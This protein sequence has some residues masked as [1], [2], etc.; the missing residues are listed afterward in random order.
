MRFK[1]SS[2]KLVEG[3]RSAVEVATKNVNTEF[4][5]SFHITLD[6]RKSEIIALA[7]GGTACISSAISGDNID[8]LNYSCEEE[9]EVTINASDFFASLSSFPPSQKVSIVKNNGE[10]VIS[11]ENEKDIFQTLPVL[12]NR[13]N[14]S[15]LPTSFE[16]EMKINREVFIEGLDKVHFAIGFAET[17]P[18]YLCI[19]FET[20]KDKAR[21]AAGT[22][23]RFAIS[24]TEGKNII[25]TSKKQSVLFPKNNISTIINVL[26]VDSSTDISIKEAKQTKNSPEQIVIQSEE[27]TLVLLGIDSSLKYSDVSKIL[28]H[29]YSYKIVSNISDWKYSMQGISATYND[30]MKSGKMIPITNVSI[31]SKKKKLIMETKGQMKAKR[32]VSVDDISKNGD[33]DIPSFKCNSLYLKEVADKGEKSEKVVLEFDTDQTPVTARFADRVNDSKNTVDKFSIF[34]VKNK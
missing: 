11:S 2:G 3:L 19:Y 34:F 24:D 26:K 10:I 21:F 4:E 33:E 15:S 5:S 23:A 27:I 20:S 30:E 25:Q 16:K 22:G 31:D 18:Y 32:Q 13:V 8:S 7:H 29:S 1:I 9:G 14:V 6:I 12:K 28:K 17:T